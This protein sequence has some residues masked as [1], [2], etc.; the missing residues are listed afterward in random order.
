MDNNLYKHGFFDEQLPVDSYYSESQSLRVSRIL[1]WN[2][3]VLRVRTDH[4]DSLELVLLLLPERLK[5]I[6]PVQESHVCCYDNITMTHNSLCTLLRHIVLQSSAVLMAFHYSIVY[7][8]A[9]YYFLAAETHTAKPRVRRLLSASHIPHRSK[10]SNHWSIV[11]L[12][13]QTGLYFHTS[14][15]QKDDTSMRFN[16]SNMFLFWQVFP[17]VRILSKQGK[18]WKQITVSKAKLWCTVNIVCQYYIMSLANC[19][20]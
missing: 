7:D 6:L 1:H 4:Y 18:M 19:L 10:R 2:N 11:G 13:Q 9:V 15:M 12:V 3:K 8:I 20:L 16:R 5:L 14:L 17:I